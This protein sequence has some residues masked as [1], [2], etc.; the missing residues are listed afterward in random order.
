MFSIALVMLTFPFLATG[1]EIQQLPRIGDT[2]APGTIQ[3]F[4]ISSDGRLAVISGVEGKIIRLDTLTG[5]K[6]TLV[7][8]YPYSVFA[9]W[10]PA[11]ATIL[12]KSGTWTHHTKYPTSPLAPARGLTGLSSARTGDGCSL[13]LEGPTR[14][15]CLMRAQAH[16]SSRL[17]VTHSKLIRLHFGLMVS[18]LVLLTMEPSDCGT[19]TRARRFVPSRFLTD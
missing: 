15:R 19:Q 16:A 4:T 14:L 5:R 1:S 13:Q 8:R 9:T 12:S 11:A 17:K 6:R 2:A 3:D 18:W 7:S 10:P